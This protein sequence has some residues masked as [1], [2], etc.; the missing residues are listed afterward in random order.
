M[1]SILIFLSLLAAAQG[2]AADCNY[3]PKTSVCGVPIDSN[4]ATFEKT[5]GAPDGTINMGKD[6]VGL[7]YGQKTLLVFWRDKLWQIHAWEN[8]SNIDFWSF[9]RNSED[10]INSR[11]IIAGWGPWGLSR[12]E[13]RNYLNQ[14]KTI[15]GDQFSEVMQLPDATLSVLYEPT[16]EVR[17]DPND[18]QKYKIKHLIIQLTSK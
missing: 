16:F 3:I 13:C 17:V 8:N 6:R 2:F 12:A 7:L 14:F 4:I 1:R 10:R 9:V 18:W 11:F 15:D 5:L